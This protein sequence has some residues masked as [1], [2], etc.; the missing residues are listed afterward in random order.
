[1]PQMSGPELVDCLLAARSMKVIYIS[2]F[3]EA[4]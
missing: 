2:G 1:M 3:T 4:K